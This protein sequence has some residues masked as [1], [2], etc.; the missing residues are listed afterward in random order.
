MSLFNRALIILLLFISINTL[1]QETAVIF[2]NITDKNHKAIE[3]VNVSAFGYSGGTTTNRNGYY[4]LVIPANK[5]ISL[6]FSCIGYKTERINIFLHPETKREI[7]I[8]LIISTTELPD[9][10]IK[11]NRIRKTSLIRIDPKETTFIPTISGG[12]EDLIKT[13]PG[14][15]SN[16]ELSSQYSVRGGNFDENLV[17]VNGIE[18]YR[19]FLIRSGQQ[20]GLS[21]LNSS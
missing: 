14:V 18:I 12:I 21:F 13:L 15:S 9:F 2:G 17:Y 1:G 5:E 19:P 16:N 7:N 6:L 11:D 3:L 8:T 20:E 4:E 10:E